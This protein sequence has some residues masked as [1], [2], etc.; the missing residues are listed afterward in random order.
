MS[1]TLGGK[2]QMLGAEIIWGHVWQLKCQLSLELSA[3]FLSWVTFVRPLHAA[4]A[5]SQHTLLRWV[6]LLIWCQ[7]VSRPVFKLT[8]QELYRLPRFSLRILTAS[9]SLHFNSYKQ[10]KSPSV[11]KRL[12]V[13]CVIGKY[14]LPQ[15]L[16]IW[17]DFLFISII[18][19]YSS[20]MNNSIYHVWNV[21]ITSFP[22][23][24]LQNVQNCFLEFNIREKIP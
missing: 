12:C 13:A 17:G 10:V 19:S 9:L 4:W 3:D 1:G 24:K 20:C 5:S 22:I 21:R 23:N 15:A 11:F 14:N 8:R 18:P 16:T 6:K 2:T 7:R